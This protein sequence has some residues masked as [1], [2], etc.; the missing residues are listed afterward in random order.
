M[1]L[2]DDVWLFLFTYQPYSY[3]YYSPGYSE[4]LLERIDNYQP[5]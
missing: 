3:R 1:C 5:N 4:T 2:I